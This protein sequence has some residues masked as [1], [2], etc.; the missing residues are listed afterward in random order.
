MI[1]AQNSLMYFVSWHRLSYPTFTVVGVQPPDSLQVPGLQLRERR[2]GET[3]R[4]YHVIVSDVTCPIHNR[5]NNVIS[6]VIRHVI[7][8]IETILHEHTQKYMFG[9]YHY[10]RSNLLKK[11]CLIII[12]FFHLWYDIHVHVVPVTTGTNVQCLN[13][14]V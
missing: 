5:V 3:G 8:W 1:L 10:C 2:R 6:R 14:H 4:D 13:I 12:H 9:I 11:D 7:K